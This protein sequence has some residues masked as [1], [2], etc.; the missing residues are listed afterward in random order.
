MTQTLIAELQ[1]NK[2]R[3]E[4]YTQLK[5]RLTLNPEEVGATGEKGDS[6]KIQLSVRSAHKHPSK[7]SSSRPISHKEVF[8]SPVEKWID[9]YA[10][11]IQKLEK[12]ISKL[13][14]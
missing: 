2:K 8:G 4:Y 9:I 11:R 3:L 14:S 6:G 10:S 7:K 12:Q 5:G 13:C 1:H